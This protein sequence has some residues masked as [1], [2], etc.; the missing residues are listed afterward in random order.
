MACTCTTLVLVTQLIHCIYT[1]YYNTLCMLCT[2]SN[3]LLLEYVHPPSLSTSSLFWRKLRYSFDVRVHVLPNPL[4]ITYTCSCILGMCCCI[5]PKSSLDNSNVF[6]VT[7]SLLST[8]P[9]LTVENVTQAMEM[10]TVDKRK[11]SW[12]VVFGKRALVEENYSS[13]SSEEE[14][15]QYCSKTY[16]TSKV[17]SSWEDL[18]QKLYYHGE[19]AAAKKAK[20]FLQQ[21]GK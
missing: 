1:S 4:L 8:D 6:I 9:T 19:L 16:V 7:I 20:T 5:S 11:Q 21:K 13:H 15:L 18:V 10:V 14:R 17:N 3:T 12:E 2:L